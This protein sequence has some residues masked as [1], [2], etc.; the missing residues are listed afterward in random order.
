MALIQSTSQHTANA[1][2]MVF[3]DNGRTCKPS[4]RYTDSLTKKLDV[5]THNDRNQQQHTN[6]NDYDNDND[7]D[8]VNDN[9]DNAKDTKIRNQLTN[10]RTNDGER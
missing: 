8:N 4:S 3:L 2:A 1:N 6:D 10:E 5:A 7:D 9:D